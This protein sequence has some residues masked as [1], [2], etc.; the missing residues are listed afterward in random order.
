MATRQPKFSLHKRW[1]ERVVISQLSETAAIW[2][3]GVMRILCP[4]AQK[5][6]SCMGRIQKCCSCFHALSQNWVSGLVGF[7]Q[8][9]HWDY[10][11]SRLGE[12]YMCWIKGASLVYKWLGGCLAPSH[13]LNKN[14]TS[15]RLNDVLCILLSVAVTRIK[16]SM[17]CWLL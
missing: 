5:W 1:I 15:D 2:H 7:T 12:G 8:T 14:V 3:V 17:F 11:S 10:N 4:L 6:L 9:W 16:W 13:Y